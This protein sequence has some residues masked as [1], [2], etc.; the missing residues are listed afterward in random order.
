MLDDTTG[1]TRP[2]LDRRT[3]LR[4]GAWAAPALVV[5]AAVPTASASVVNPVM[6]GAFSIF[7]GG[8]DGNV[9]ARYESGSWTSS[10]LAQ[11]TITSTAGVLGEPT[12]QNLNGWQ[13]ITRSPTSATLQY[14]AAPTGNYWTSPF[15]AWFPFTS[16]PSAASISINGLIAGTRASGFEGGPVVGP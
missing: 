14:P 7:D 13:V 12:A 8:L 15:L 1:S 6:G 16:A 5:A 3:L 4:T 11:I 9:S 2:A 10:N